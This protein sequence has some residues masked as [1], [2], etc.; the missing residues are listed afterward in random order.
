MARSAA[1]AQAVSPAVFQQIPP[2]SSARFA[3][4]PILAVDDHPGAGDEHDAASRPDA[5][6]QGSQR[7]IF[8]LHRYAGGQLSRQV[9]K[10]TAFFRPVDAGQR[11]CHGRDLVEANPRALQRCLDSLSEGGTHPWQPHV[12]IIGR[13]A[14]PA[15]DHL[16]L[17]VQDHGY[18][19]TSTTIYADNV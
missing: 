7:V 9:E 16:A 18:R 19:L 10:G 11:P 5:S 14:L 2:A 6:D 13:A 17:L 15:P 3:P 8:D 12:I 1:L 4:L